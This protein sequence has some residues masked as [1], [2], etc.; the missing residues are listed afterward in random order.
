MSTRA[1]AKVL[2]G[3]ETGPIVRIF[4]YLQILDILTTLVGLKLGVSEASPFVK[5]LMYFGPSAGLAG[6]KLLGVAL[7]SIA[8]VLQ[9]PHL[10]RWINYWYATLIVWNLFALVTAIKG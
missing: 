8:I 9:K 1:I 4:L 3:S 10:L 6:S 5:Y 2:T 7:A